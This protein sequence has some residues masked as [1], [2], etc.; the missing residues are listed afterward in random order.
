MD[1]VSW[2]LIQY[3]LAKLCAFHGDDGK[4]QE[5][6]GKHQLAQTDGLEKQFKGLF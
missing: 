5:L 6:S 2:L 1:A 4:L 3:I